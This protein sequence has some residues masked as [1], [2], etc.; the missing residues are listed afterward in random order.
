MDRVDHPDKTIFKPTDSDGFIY[1]AQHAIDA[2]AERGVPSRFI[3]KG[4]LVVV[5][6]DE[7]AVHV[8]SQFLKTNKPLNASAPIC[9]VLCHFKNTRRSIQNGHESQNDKRDNFS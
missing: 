6:G 2:A 1:V 8:Y 4:K 3:Y 9:D 7:K 5:H